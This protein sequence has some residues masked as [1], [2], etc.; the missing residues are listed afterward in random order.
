LAVGL[1][2]ATAIYGSTF[3]A[4]LPLKALA[5]F[6]DGDLPT[7]P[8]E[9]KRR[10]TESGQALGEIPVVSAWSDRISVEQP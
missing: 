3:N 2:C 5:Y 9:V 7:L 8:A 10:L 1:A 4:M 6:E